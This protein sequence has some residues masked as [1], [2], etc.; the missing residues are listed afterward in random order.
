MF[1]K[2]FTLKHYSLNPSYPDIQPIKNVIPEWYKKTERFSDGTKTIKKLP[3]SFTLKACG[4]FGDSFMTGYYIPL[5]VDIAVEQTDVGPSISW[6]DDQNQFVELRD[7]SVN[8]RLPIP[9][10]YAPLQ[11]TWVTKHIFKIPKG[12]SALFTHP[13]NRLD[14][15]F[16]TLSG[17]VDGKISLHNGNLPVFFNNTFEGVIPAGTPIAQIILFKNKK[18]KSK[19][20]K[21]I[22]KD[23]LINAERSKNS[24]GWYKKNHWKKKFYE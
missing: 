14:L 22:L 12:Y 20:D 9:H 11:F 7:S 19:K 18:W 2:M 3:V 17:I 23:A 6:V 15:P 10:G 16:F 21:N 8:K 1:K 5:P 24:F 4:P 13:L